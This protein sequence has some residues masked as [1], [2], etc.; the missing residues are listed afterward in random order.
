MRLT[1]QDIIKIVCDYYDIDTEIML[2]TKSRE[3]TLIRARQVS[4]YF[5]RRKLK[6]SQASIGNIFG[7][8]HATALKA[9]ERIENLIIIYPDIRKNIN[10]L[11]REIDL[12]NSSIEDHIFKSIKNES[13][14]WGESDYYPV[15][16]K[17]TYKTIYSTNY[18]FRPPN[19][20]MSQERGVTVNGYSGFREH[21]R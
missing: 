4:M 16:N 6:L 7:R 5:I 10:D 8:N 18:H 13:S 19:P 3:S 20:Y 17:V 11:N 2:N 21:S 9:I 14:V 12:V 15:E 1:E